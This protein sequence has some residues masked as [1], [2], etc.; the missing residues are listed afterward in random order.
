M[1]TSTSFQ[2]SGLVSL[3]F[4]SIL[5]SACGGPGGTA[6][7]GSGGSATPGENTGGSASGGGVGTGGEPPPAPVML[8]DSRLS[9]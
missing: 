2:V 6:D 9:A 1:E 7:E 8:P 3:V 5:P 4:L